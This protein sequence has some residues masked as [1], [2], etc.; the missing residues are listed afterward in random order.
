MTDIVLFVHW[1]AII[2]L[3]IT[4]IYFVIQI[5]IGYGR[6]YRLIIMFICVVAI[7]INLI[8]AT[9]TEVKHQY[10]IRNMKFVE[11]L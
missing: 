7:I 11:K 5:A 8:C 10:K 4:I 2:L 1:I 3:S 6:K 9:K